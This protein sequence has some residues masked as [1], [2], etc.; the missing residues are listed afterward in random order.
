M[1]LALA[2]AVLSVLVSACYAQENINPQEQ[3]HWYTTGQKWGQWRPFTQ[4]PSLSIRGACGDDTT[5]NGIP[6][7]TLQTQ[8]RSGYGQPMAIIWAEEMYNLETKRN[9][10][11]GSFL[12]YLEPGQITMGIS[13]LR[14]NCSAAPTFY[15]KMKCVA[16]KGEEGAACFKD[17]QG[18][19]IAERTNQFRSFPPASG[20]KAGPLDANAGSSSTPEVYSYLWC[21]VGRQDDDT[22]N[23]VSIGFYGRVFRIRATDDLRKI[24]NGF[25]P[26]LSSQFGLPPQSYTPP[27]H[28]FSGAQCS[29]RFPTQAAAEEGRR[30]SLEAARQGLA[31]PASQG[32]GNGSNLKAVGE[33]KEVDWP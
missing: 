5:V 6:M 20:S 3:P 7:F 17:S 10:V 25:Q 21:F 19:P 11:S 13:A 14:G 27:A 8:I 23:S 26:W 12:E 29:A 16:R 33:I 31:H 15:A 22:V 28:F 4:F 30:V 32:M 1:R 9:I 18:N 24:E 2:F